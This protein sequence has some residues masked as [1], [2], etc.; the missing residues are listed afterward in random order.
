MVAHV[1][2]Y[3][4]DIAVMEAAIYVSA[5]KNATFVFSEGNDKCKITE[6]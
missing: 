3:G 5:D 4:T 1:G 2:V 6:F